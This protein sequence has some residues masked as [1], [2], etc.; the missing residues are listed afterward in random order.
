LHLTYEYFE[1]SIIGNK[2]KKAILAPI[3]IAP[4]NLSGIDFKIA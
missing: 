3:A 4:P 1:V 2:N